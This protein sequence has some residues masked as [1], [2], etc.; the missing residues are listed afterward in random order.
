MQGWILEFSCPR[1]S[2]RNG[3]QL[4][5][6]APQG[7]ARR[8]FLGCELLCQTATID[9]SNDNTKN[10]TSNGAKMIFPS[11]RGVGFKMN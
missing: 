4:G 6:L 7:G 5:V 10:N 2:P 9:V 3:S 11:G 8:D 1:Q